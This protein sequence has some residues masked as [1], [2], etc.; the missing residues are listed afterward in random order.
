MNSVKS[1]IPL[2]FCFD[3]DNAK[4]KIYT[5]DYSI[6][7]KINKVDTNHINS[8]DRYI[9]KQDDEVIAKLVKVHDSKNQERGLFINLNYCELLYETDIIPSKDAMAF[10]MGLRGNAGNRACGLI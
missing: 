10:V 7:D 5:V 1:I 2:L 8:R 3:F 4:A 6:L 9:F